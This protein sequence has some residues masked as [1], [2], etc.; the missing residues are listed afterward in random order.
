MSALV[1]LFFD[2]AVLIGTD[3]LASRPYQEGNA[4]LKPLMF[5]Q[6]VFH[7]PHLKSVVACLGSYQVSSKFYEFVN[8]R[9]V[10][11]DIN[12]I[13]IVG[14]EAFRK[15]LEETSFTK[16]SASIYLYGYDDSLKKFIG[17]RAHFG[18]NHEETYKWIPLRSSSELLGQ[19]IF[20][21]QPPVDDCWGKLDL[22]FAKVEAGMSY[23]Q[24]I[25]RIMIIQKNEDAERTA[26]Q[27]VGIGGDIVLTRL[28]INDSGNFTISMMRPLFRTIC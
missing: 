2:N 14:L 12:S 5:V 22:L 3:T 28:Y 9:F 17:Y 21:M 8:Q 15:F 11:K 20:I 16:H 7:L 1:S 25:E 4:D 24:F 27:Q 19:P 18:P 6:K 13:S 26:N 23:E 10:G